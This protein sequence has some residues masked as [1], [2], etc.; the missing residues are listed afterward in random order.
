MT[1]ATNEKQSKP[2]PE[3]ISAEIIMCEHVSCRKTALMN[4]PGVGNA[5]Q[6]TDRK[7]YQRRMLEFGL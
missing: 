2:M 7:P 1:Q 6:H 3:K 5:V 4:V